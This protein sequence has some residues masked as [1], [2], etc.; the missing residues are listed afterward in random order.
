MFFNF[1]FQFYYPD[2]FFFVVLKC[3]KTASKKNVSH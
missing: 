2:N 1:Y 3:K